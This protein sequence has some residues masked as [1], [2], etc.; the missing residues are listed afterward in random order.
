MMLSSVVITLITRGPKEAII[1]TVTGP[2]RAFGRLKTT[3][4]LGIAAVILGAGAA[5]V[6]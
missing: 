5:M 6:I 2:F 1:G 4:R 3:G